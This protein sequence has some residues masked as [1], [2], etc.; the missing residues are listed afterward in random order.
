MAAEGEI[1]ATPGFAGFATSANGRKLLL[2]VGIAAVIAIIAG[3]I[4]WSQKPD[5]RVLFSNFSD[6]DGGAIVAALEQINVPYKYAEG[7]SAIL[8][9]ADRVHDLRLKLAA[10]GLPK[11]GNV[12]F[13]LMENQKL[14]TSQFLEQVNFQRALEGEL[15]QTIEAVSAIQA[16]RVH[17]ALP[18]ASV[19]VRDQ[20]KPTASVLLNLQPGRALDAGQVSAIVHLVASSVP[21]LTPKNEIGRASCR[22]RV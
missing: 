3:V 5:Y 15:A 1:V 16:A 11:G 9:P 20:Q 10:Q 2:M 21:E 7:G 13:E 12:G 8:V 18:K 22:E 4:M 19:F 6:K 17:L 14:G